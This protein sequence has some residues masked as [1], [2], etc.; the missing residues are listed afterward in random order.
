MTSVPS[1]GR[2]FG[3]QGRPGRKLLGF[4]L[5][6]ALKTN[7]TAPPT[8]RVPLASHLIPDDGLDAGGRIWSAVGP[9]GGQRG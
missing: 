4:M 6:Q 7:L 8:D 9:G 2:E 5:Y 3:E 1:P